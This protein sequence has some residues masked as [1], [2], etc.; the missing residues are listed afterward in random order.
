M[1]WGGTRRRMGG[2][3]AGGGGGLHTSTQTL[4]SAVAVVSVAYTATSLRPVNEPGRGGGG[5]G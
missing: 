3:W 1:E 2:R 4:C 5:G